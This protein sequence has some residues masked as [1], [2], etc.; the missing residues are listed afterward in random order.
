M[1][2][3]FLTTFGR[4]FVPKIWQPHMRRFFEKTGK[5]EVPF[6]TVGILFVVGVLISTIIHVAQVQPSIQQTSLWLFVLLSGILWAVL[7]FAILF[8][9][10]ATWYFYLT[11]LIYHRTKQM[12]EMLPD[13]LTLVSTSLKGGYAFERSLWSA[14]KPEFG[15]LAKEIGLVSKR[16]MTGNDV[17][18]AMMDFAQKYESPLLRRSLD[19]IIGELES[20]GRVVDVIDRV[21]IDLKKTKS[22]KEEMVANTLTY[23]IFISALVMFIMPLLFAL[24]FVLFKVITHFLGNISS[25]MQTAP[26]AGISLRGGGIDPADYE[27]FS[28]MAIAVIATFS[29]LI[30]SIIEKGDMRGGIKY[31]P[32][33]LFTSE[34]VYFICS[35][36]LAKIF[37]TFVP[38]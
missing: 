7:T 29:A 5:D 33:F 15:I 37:S 18:V 24:S 1:E 34:I 6:H 16:V 19:L 31:V 28:Y 38:L 25:S 23:V 10:G 27:R 20:G 21:I 36:L 3:L 11:M 9:L 4:A 14:I 26:V 12:E 22:I 2:I 30:V 35:L 13:Y 17:S 8:V 32:M